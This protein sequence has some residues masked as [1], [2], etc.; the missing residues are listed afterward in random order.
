MITKYGDIITKK[1]I[2]LNDYAHSEVDV[3]TLDMTT[4][5]NVIPPSKSVMGLGV[6]FSYKKGNQN[7]NLGKGFSLNLNETFKENEDA[8]VFADYVYT[9]GKG[10]KHGFKEYFYYLNDDK[11]RVYIS[12][13]ALEDATVIETELAKQ[14]RLRESIT[15][16]LDG[17]LEFTVDGKK[18][19]VFPEYRSATKVKAMPNGKEYINFSIFENRSTEEKQM[20]ERL[21]AL[22]NTLKDFRY[23]Y[24]N[25]KDIGSFLF[26]GTINSKAHDYLSTIETTTM[27]LPNNEA[28]QY[29]MLKEQRESYCADNV[30]NIV[31]SDASIKRTMANL[32]RQLHNLTEQCKVYAQNVSS[33]YKQAII[34]ALN[35]ESENM[36]DYINE[37]VSKEAIDSISSTTTVSGSAGYGNITGAVFKEMLRE[38]NMY[39]EQLQAIWE[40]YNANIFNFNQ[41]ILSIE[42]KKSAYIYQIKSY[43]KEYLNLEKEYNEL[44]KHK[45][46]HFITDRDGKVIKGY[47]KDGYLVSVFDRNENY[48]M[49]E[50]EEGSTTKVKRIVDNNNNA[51]TFEYDLDGKLSCIVDVSGGKTEFNYSE[52]KVNLTKIIYPTAVELGFSVSE[53]ELVGV[54]CTQDYDVEILN[55]SSASG[56]ETSINFKQ[57]LDIVK[58]YVI[59]NQGT[60]KSFEKTENGI[61]NR[62]EYTYLPDGTPDFIFYYDSSLY[63]IEIPGVSVNEDIQN[64]SIIMNK[65]IYTEDVLENGNIPTAPLKDKNETKKYDK[66]NN[67][68]EESFYMWAD[69]IGEAKEIINT[70]YTYDDN[71]KLIRKEDSKG[72]DYDNPTLEVQYVGYSTITEYF[73]DAKGELI[74][75]ET[76]SLGKE[77]SKGRTIVEYVYDEKGNLKK[78]FTYNTLDSSSKFYTETGL[79]QTGENKVEQEELNADGLTA[80]E[81]LPNGSKLAYGYDKFGRVTAI[82]HSTESGESNST[83]KVFDEV[84]RVKKVVSGNT[85]IEYSYDG[86][87]R[88][89]QI[90]LNGETYANYTYA[91]NTSSV[92]TTITYANGDVI[93]EEYDFAGRLLQ[94][95]NNGV[96]TLTNTYD[97]GNLKKSTFAD[98]T[99]KDFYYNTKNQIVEFGD[100]PTQVIERDIFGNIT[101]EYLT[102]YSWDKYRYNYKD[103]FTGELENIII[104]NNYIL[105]P[106]IDANGR[107]I[108]KEINYTDEKISGEYI[109]YRKVGDHATNMPSTIRFGDAT[110]GRFAIKDSIKYEYDNMGN[111]V[112]VFE[113]G[114]LSVRYQYDA[115]GRL[116]REDNKGLDKTVVI[117]YD[118]NGNI[119]KKKEYAF[120]LK[121]SYLLEEL[122]CVEKEY[123]Y[124]GDKLLSYN[125]ESCEYNSVGNPIVYRNKSATW[126][127][128]RQLVSY[129]GNTF[130]YDGFGNRTQKNSN[131]TYYD[132]NNN[133]MFEYVNGIEIDWYR[134]N[135]GIVGCCFTNISNYETYWLR[136]DALGNVVAI[137]NNSGGIVARYIYD[138]WGNHKVVDNNGNEITDTTHIGNINP[139]RYRGYYFDTETGLYYLKS[140]YYDPET[141]R[142]IS[143][144]DISFADPDTINGLNLYAYCCNNPVMHI[145][146][147][148]QYAIS[149]VLIGLIIG[150]I[151]GAAVGGTIA[152]VN[153]YNNGARG[154][155]LVGWTALGIVG[156]SVIGGAIGAGIGYVAPAI[157]GALGSILGGSSLA[158]VGGGA[159]AL[160]GGQIAVA[161][162]LSILAGLGIVF[163]KG[164]GPRLGHNQH[165]KQMWNE[166]MHRLDIKD[167]D[168]RKRLHN[169]NHKYPYQNTLKGLIRQLEDILR[170]W[171]E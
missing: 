79:D 157:G 34:N 106:K 77:D 121:E 87:G 170:K 125:G 22:K 5:I 45:P 136:K 46:S 80:F 102:L 81:K 124:D 26:S 59:K 40:E 3:S 41:M 135:T 138:A 73:Y 20:E 57:G 49:I 10:N 104:N 4:H 99:Q 47:H 27:L 122:A 95:K 159:I 60:L 56:N 88:V 123:I 91:E 65:I 44:I 18:R 31:S 160:S 156:G 154:W 168:V 151:I 62:E 89:S 140:R 155:E 51:V 35:F 146:P 23:V 30:G 100:T 153:A 25:R 14:K 145:D 105:T 107:N 71:Q 38:R 96:A 164:N 39:V 7:E 69:N 9:D 116:I 163:S 33:S 137:L 129:N 141:G 143:I 43:I 36:T 147:T 50:Y 148:G 166:A 139:Y 144:D 28:I 126:Q 90:K 142:F 13:P 63:K 132:C 114:N 85:V 64:P 117:V 111:I 32:E 101:R 86:K 48:A 42:K 152:G 37:L 118:N 158:T 165:E 2:R 70:K 29:K 67:L 82:S 149:A 169:E 162:G 113:N 74:R 83:E 78:S 17:K 15:I 76:Y 134:D 54:T 19:E 1:K 11:E 161:S 72:I 128:G 84:G 52:E 127:N 115:L 58:K 8:T 130:S 24:T 75:T 171:S 55:I 167:K 94:R 150:A 133:V 16:N 12:A 21:T 93:S 66:F 109:T 131:I 110:S 6:N 92:T 112:K 97:K 108:G 119:L 61:S 120:T 98:G 103:V 53:D 68:I